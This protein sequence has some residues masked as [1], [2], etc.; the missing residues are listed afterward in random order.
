MKITVL[1][2]YHPN[3]PFPSTDLALT[4]PDGLLAVGGCLSPTRILNAYRQGIFPWFNPDDP[5]L[6]WSP[7]PRFVLF[8]AQLHISRRLAKTLR[9]ERFSFKID[10]AFSQVIDAC[11]QPRI[12]SN[13]TWISDGIKQAYTQLHQQGIAHS[14]EAWFEGELVGGLYGIAMGQ[15]FFGESMFHRKT[16]ASKVA[17]AHLVTHLSHWGYQLI[18]CQVYTEHLESLGA[19]EIPRTDFVKYLDRYCENKV[20][21]KA[22]QLQ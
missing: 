20:D 15:L 6:W 19:I 11:S 2:P 16:D 10:S 7:N 17:F 13:G 21:I 18:D 1:N 14:A 4:E 8:P 9:S 3:Q 22:W 12:D 5:I